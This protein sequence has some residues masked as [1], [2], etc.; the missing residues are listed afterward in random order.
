MTK[1]KHSVTPK[2]FTDFM[3]MYNL[4]KFPHERLGQAFI[5]EFFTDKQDPDLFYEEDNYDAYMTIMHKYVD[6]DWTA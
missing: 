3:R 1:S 4:K 5:N 2:A 6:W